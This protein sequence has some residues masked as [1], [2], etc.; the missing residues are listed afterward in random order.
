M[1]FENLSHEALSIYFP[2]ETKISFEVSGTPGG[3]NN[4]TY[5]ITKDHKDKHILR[6]YN[7]GNNLAKVNA[8]HYVLNQLKHRQHQHQYQEL[9]FKLPSLIRPPG[10]S[11]SYTI[12]SNG[13][14]A[15]LFEFIEGVL[16]KPM[17]NLASLT[18]IGRATG[19]LCKAM[20][21]ISISP[22]SADQLPLP[23]PT[24]PYWDLFRA[25]EKMNRERFYDE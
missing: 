22:I 21:Q 8:E 15:C 20:E 14:A 1:D 6:I 17:L 23:L 25:H 12:L 5:L 3:V 24:P 4:R 2:S 16:A 13:T 11:L 9:T 19:E 7:N 18:E 10:S